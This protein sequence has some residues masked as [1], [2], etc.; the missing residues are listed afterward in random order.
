MLF[1]AMPFIIL[2]DIRTPKH[3]Y[4]LIIFPV[5]SIYLFF[6][7]FQKSPRILFDDEFLTAKYLFNEKIYSWSSIADI[8]LSRKENNMLQRMEATSIIFDNG[9]KLNIWQ[10]VYSNCEEMRSYISK[11][12]F[13]KIRDPR[14]NIISKNLQAITRKRY[15]G[16]IFTSFNTL[17]VVGM[18][19]FMGISIKGK[20]KYEGLLIIPVGFILLLFFGVGTQMNYFLI[21]EGYLF[22]KNHFFPW[23]NKQIRLEDIVEVDIE[24]PYKRSTGLRIITK[25]FNSKMYGAGSLRDK[26]WEDLLSDLKL[27]GIP[28]RDDR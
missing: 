5:L 20:V 14:P 28:A 26:N 18:A 10:N 23:I 4:I 11:K 21:D 6:S 12:S 15:S 17:L 2:Y 19:I 22:I 25:D 24:T 9:E 13:G 7:T 8:Y 27:I 3:T 1:M 16:N